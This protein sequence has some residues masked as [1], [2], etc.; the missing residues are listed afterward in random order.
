[1]LSIYNSAKV[2]SS[3]RVIALVK[4]KIAVLALV[5]ALNLEVVERVKKV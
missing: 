3:L 2:Y 1:M 5:N 4:P